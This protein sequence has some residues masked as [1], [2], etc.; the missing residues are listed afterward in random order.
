MNF[1]K[2]ICISLF[3]LCNNAKANEPVEINA[4]TKI[5][6]NKMLE[7]LLEF[8]IAK[9]WHI[10]APYEQEFGSPLKINWLDVSNADVLEESYSKTKRYV[11]DI[12]SFDGYEA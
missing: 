2:I 4:Y 5:N 3:L 1:L 8:N 10:F 12:I 6:D 9:N 7:V 11:N